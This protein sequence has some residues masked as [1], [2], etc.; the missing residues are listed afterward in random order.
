LSEFQLEKSTWEALIPL[1]MSAINSSPTVRLSGRSPREVFMGEKSKSILEEIVDTESEEDISLKD[2]PEK[3]EEILEA[4][5]KDY[6]EMLDSVKINLE[7][8]EVPEYELFEPGDLILYAIRPSAATGKLDHKWRGPMVVEKRESS[9]AYRIRDPLTNKEW[10]AHPARILLFQR[11]GDPE[12]YKYQRVAISD[13]FKL[14]EISDMWQDEENPDS[15][16]VAVK[17]SG[18]HSWVESTEDAQVVEEKYP[19]KFAKFMEVNEETQVVRDF[20]RK[21]SLGK[22]RKCRGD[23]TSQDTNQQKEPSKQKNSDVESNEASRIRYPR[24]AKDKHRFFP[25]KKNT[26]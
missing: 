4:L 12:V 19:R 17:W 26:D 18:D 3:L 14:A 25:K 1:V 24:K 6:N 13:H 7:E 23:P 9:H 16:R 2:W 21:C 8:E 5:E 22:G 11:G 10:I 15:F 20:N